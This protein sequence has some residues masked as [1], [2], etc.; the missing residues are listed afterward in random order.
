MRIKLII[1][2]DGTAYCGWQRQDN[3]VAVQ[4]VLEEALTAL[5][6][7]KVTVRGAGRTDS[8]V[9]ARGQTVHFDTDATIPP[10]R[11]VLAL[12]PLLPPDIR[13]RSAQEAP[14]DFDARYSAIGKKYEYRIYNGPYLPPL[15]RLD[16]CFIPAPLDDRAMARAAAAFAGVHDFAAFAAA[17]HRKGSTVREVFSCEV[18]RRGREILISVSGRSFLYNMVRIMAGTLI[19]VG[20][21]KIP[22]D[23]VPGIIASKDRKQ[24]GRT[25]PAHGLTLAEVYY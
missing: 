2:Y 15:M 13:V 18:T 11:Y 4:Q 3:G 14:A 24:A 7:R 16:H 22:A 1:E 10:Q 17:D 6:G 23:A 21:G 20:L 19:E 5:T 25:A 9:H 8:G 12:N